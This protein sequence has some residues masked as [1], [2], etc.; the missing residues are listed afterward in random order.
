MPSTPI[1]PHRVILLRHHLRP[2]SPSVLHRIYPSLISNPTT[3]GY[4]RSRSERQHR[5]R[6]GRWR[7][8]QEQQQ[9]WH[10]SSSITAV[11]A[12]PVAAG[13][14]GCGPTGA[15]CCYAA[16]AAAAALSAFGE[17]IPPAYVTLINALG[18]GLTSG[19]Y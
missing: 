19:F 4:Q 9:Q 1:V 5:G 15:G 11:V 3:I 14:A 12:A 17:W 6:W 13:A 16:T 8:R 7:R 10:S 18:C 2:S